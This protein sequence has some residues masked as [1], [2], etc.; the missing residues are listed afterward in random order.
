MKPY[1]GYIEEVLKEYKVLLGGGSLLV[2]ISGIAEYFLPKSVPRQLHI[3]ILMACLVS[4]LVRHGVGQYRRL[5][6]R[7]AIRGLE[8]RVWPYDRHGFTGA[9]YFLK[10]PT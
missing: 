1:V 8:R 5:M 6:P 9:E 10:W 3:W 2:V 7:I 4:A